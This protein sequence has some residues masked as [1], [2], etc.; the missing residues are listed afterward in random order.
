M[1]VCA[2]VEHDAVVGESHLLQLRYQFPF[3]VALIVV[4]VDVGIA[5]S[6]SVEIGFHRVRTVY[7]RFACAQ[8]IKIWA[9]NYLYF[10]YFKKKLLYLQR[11]STK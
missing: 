2:G 5:L 6:Q 11:K 10:H 3:D 9:I 1:R 7:S 8:E 4:D